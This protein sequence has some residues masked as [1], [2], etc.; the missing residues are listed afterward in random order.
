MWSDNLIG[1]RKKHENKPQP[2][3]E[4]TEKVEFNSTLDVTALENMIVED[5]KEYHR[6]LELGREIKLIINRIK[7][8]TL[9]LRKE[10]AEALELFETCRQVEIKS[11]D[12]RPWRGGGGKYKIAS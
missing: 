5:I 10:H 1:H 11:I 6:K 2:I 4:V 3:D 12:W 7:A 9:G 8:P